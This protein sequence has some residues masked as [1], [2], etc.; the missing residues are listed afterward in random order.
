LSESQT[1][2]PA[3]SL[4]DR[5]ALIGLLGP[6]EAISVAEGADPDAF[7]RVP[8][9]VLIRTMIERAIA[10]EGLT[11][12]ATGNLSR[13]DIRAFFDG[14]EWPD[15]DKE[16]ILWVS[17]VLN[18]RDVMP[19]HIARIVAQEGRLLR[20][21]KSRLLATKLAREMIAPGREVAL[22]RMIFRTLI[23]RINAAYFDANHIEDWPQDHVGVVLWSLSVA[24]HDWM[25]RAAVTAIC[26]FPY[27]QEPLNE[28]HR[29][30]H[31]VESRILQPLTWLGLMESRRTIADREL[32]PREYRL[33][34][35]FKQSLKF[36]VDLTVGPAH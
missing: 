32:S 2:L 31:A 18:E 33:M 11:L 19:V 34:P 6:S 13:A 3:W 9:L 23:W 12:T 20:R 35:L 5:K 26:T 28:W 8:L 4:L 10:N 29:P 15:Y 25:S 36:D 16:S 21:Q 30:E 17:K 27:R 14:L 7:R 1:I 24:A 22:F